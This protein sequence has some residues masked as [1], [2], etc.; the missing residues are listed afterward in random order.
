MP[1]EML[2]KHPQNQFIKE[3]GPVNIINPETWVQGSQTFMSAPA[4]TFWLK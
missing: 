4:Y 3:H 2:W 1:W